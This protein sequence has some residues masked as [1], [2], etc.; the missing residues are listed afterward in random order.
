MELTSDVRLLWL[1]QHIHGDP[2]L[3][4]AAGQGDSIS[5]WIVGEKVGQLLTVGKV[6]DVFWTFSSW[7][8]SGAG[9][10]V[11]Q[12]TFQVP[13]VKNLE[14]YPFRYEVGDQG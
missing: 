9:M 1:R 13:R 3:D 6:V 14:G 11:E 7:M 12:G 10:W 2:P 5:V 8:D 4:T